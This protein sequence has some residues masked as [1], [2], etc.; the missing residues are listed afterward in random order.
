MTG[1]SNISWCIEGMKTIGVLDPL[2]AAKD[3]ITGESIMPWIC[4]AIV[5]L[6][7]GA[8]NNAS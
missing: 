2:A 4:L 7:A 8:T 3:I 6:V 5:F 1:S